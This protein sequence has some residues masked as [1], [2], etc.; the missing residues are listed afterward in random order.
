MQARPI[1][2]NE[3]HHILQTMWLSQQRLP[4]RADVSPAG[5]WWDVVNDM[6]ELQ[7]YD[8]MTPDLRAAEARLVEVGM[9]NEYFSALLAIIAPPEHLGDYE[10]AVLVVMATAYQREQAMV[11]LKKVRGR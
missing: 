6:Q 10:K 4:Y 1:L 5:I 7:G 11:E 2:T 8:V 3:E 9:A